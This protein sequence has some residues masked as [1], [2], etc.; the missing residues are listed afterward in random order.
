V[1]AGLKTRGPVH[2]HRD[3]PDG[4][5][6]AWQLLFGG[7]HGFG[8]L[9]PFYIDWRE[10]PHPSGALPIAGALEA[11]ALQTP[12]AAALEALLGELDVPVVVAEAG[13]RMLRATLETTHG[14]VVLETSPATVDLQF[15]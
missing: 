1:A 6:L 5:R 11:L 8:T 2:A 7:G 10:S 13:E 15:G 14:A 12:H 3:G 9:L 4:I